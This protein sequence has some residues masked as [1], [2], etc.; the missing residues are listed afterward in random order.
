MRHLIW[1]HQIKITLHHFCV[2]LYN[3][4]SVIWAVM[5]PPD[6]CHT[7]IDR[8]VHLLI[9]VHA[10]QCNGFSFHSLYDG[11]TAVSLVSFRDHEQRSWPDGSAWLHSLTFP[12]K[13]EKS[14]PVG[15]DY[16][17]A[18]S[19]QRARLHPPLV[20]TAKKLS[21]FP[22]QWAVLFI[23]P[24]SKYYTRIYKQ[25]R[26]STDWTVYQSRHFI[27]KTICHGAKG[28]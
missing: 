23:Y 7:I 24:Q 17:L 1:T 10:T 4:M 3:Q 11:E 26:F 13:L 19:Y 18:A 21:S 22:P 12:L 2:L 25:A 6:Y 16:S 15:L 27:L 5:A 28:K 14:L 8:W 20:F 9:V